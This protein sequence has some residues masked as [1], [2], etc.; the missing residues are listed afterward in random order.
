MAQCDWRPVI[1]ESDRDLERLVNEAWPLRPS[2]DRVG[3]AMV[4][5]KQGEL[6]VDGESVELIVSQA[7]DALQTHDHPQLEYNDEVTGYA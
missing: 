4:L 6:V 1:P 2:I 3:P 7:L 5:R